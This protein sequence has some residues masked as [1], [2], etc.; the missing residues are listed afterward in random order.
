MKMV[1]NLPRGCLCL[2]GVGFLTAVVDSVELSLMMIPNSWMW[3]YFLTSPNSWLVLEVEAGLFRQVVTVAGSES[4]RSAF[5]QMP[6]LGL[7]AV[8]C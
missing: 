2:P 4:Y 1:P 6:G 8:L 3:M 5:H 7:P